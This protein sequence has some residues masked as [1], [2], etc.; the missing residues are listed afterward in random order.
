MPCC[1]A[2]SPALLRAAACET[3]PLCIAGSSCQSGSSQPGLTA[4][5]QM[6][7]TWATPPASLDKYQ[8]TYLEALMDY[9]AVPKQVLVE[10]ALIFTKPQSMTTN[11]HGHR[12]MH[13]HTNTGT[14]MHIN[15]DAPIHTYKHRYTHIHTKHRSMFIKHAHTHTYMTYHRQCL[16]W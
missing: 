1:S 12:C 3:P 9:C 16:G 11:T 14:H 5:G 2:A 10:N 15:T 4:A 6:T 13:M 7:G 8:W